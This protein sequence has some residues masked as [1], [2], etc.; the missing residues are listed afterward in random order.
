MDDVKD[1]KDTTTNGIH[2]TS[3]IILTMNA[4]LTATGR[5]GGSGWHRSM[6]NVICTYPDL[7]F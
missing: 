3:R 1:E 4:T 2:S 6:A 7:T 5:M